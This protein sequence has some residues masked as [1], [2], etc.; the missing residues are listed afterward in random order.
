M[1]VKK[2]RRKNSGQGAPATLGANSTKE[3]PFMAM[4]PRP[5]Q[6]ASERA[7]RSTNRRADG[8]AGWG[9]QHVSHAPRDVSQL[10]AQ[11]AQ[12]AVPQ[13]DGWAL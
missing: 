8:S 2:Y 6:A 11:L 5:L 3:R 13:E 4:A 12:V 9:T 1:A 7:L 10:T